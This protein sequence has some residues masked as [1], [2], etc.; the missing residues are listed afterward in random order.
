M[1]EHCC[2]FEIVRLGVL[3]GH[4]RPRPCFSHAEEVLSTPP[5]SS[6]SLS[7]HP[8]PSHRLMLMVAIVFAESPPSSWS[9]L[10]EIRRH[11]VLS[12]F[13]SS[14]RP[15]AGAESPNRRRRRRRR[16][17]VVVD[18]A[19]SPPLMQSSTSPPLPPDFAIF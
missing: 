7:C 15:V 17:R 3:P 6:P 18:Q 16:R 19:E 8:G 9:S 10:R 13:R 1:F 12:A 14:G 5:L 2:K 11:I 4:T